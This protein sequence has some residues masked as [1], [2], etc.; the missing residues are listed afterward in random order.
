[1]AGAGSDAVMGALLGA[2]VGDCIGAPYEGG[3]SVGLAGGRRRVSRALA[4]GD[5]RG[6]V[7]GE[8]GF[9]PLLAYTD[10]TQLTLALVD[11]LV[12]DDA[13]VEPRLLARRMLARYEPHRGYGP[14][15][16]R[17]VELW[18]HGHD[19]ESAATA[20]FPDGSFGNGAAM[21]V[22]PVGLLWAGRPAELTAAAV[23][24]AQVTHAHPVGIDGAVVVAHAVALAAADR[25]FALSDLAR[26]PTDTTELGEGLAAAAQVD[27]DTAPASVAALLGTAPTAHRSVPAALWCAAVSAD[28]EECVTRAVA[29]GGD[30]DTIASMAAAVR[31]AAGGACAMPP[32][33]TAVLEGHDVVIEAAGR[34]SAVAL[35]DVGDG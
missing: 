17:L 26:L 7:A 10:D 29:F 6:P 4:R 23:R 30:T 33:W 24:S 25:R 13:R 20:V 28:V 27:R 8:A 12:D 34:L 16:R 2:L 3:R 21:R 5:R 19:V 1:M 9:R 35:A 18:R 14:G 32:A 15:M 22:A 11:H 31:G